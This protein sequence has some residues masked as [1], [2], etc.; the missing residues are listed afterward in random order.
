ME[1]SECV[2]RKFL[3]LRE[4]I[5]THLMMRHGYRHIGPESSEV[6]NGMFFWFG[7]EGT[8]G[9]NVQAFLNR[10]GWIRINHWQGRSSGDASALELSVRWSG[11]RDKF[12][13]RMFYEGDDQEDISV[14]EVCRRLL[15]NIPTEEKISACL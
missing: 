14:E 13:I 15:K 5:G 11:V 3:E 8:D 10:A 6:T 1:K 12:L 4:I 9:F 7:P 2:D